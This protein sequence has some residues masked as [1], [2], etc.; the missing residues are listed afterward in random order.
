MNDLKT[1]SSYGKLCICDID[2]LKGFLSMFRRLFCLL[3]VI[4]FLVTAVPALAEETESIFSYDFNLA[5][6]LNADSFPLMQ[7]SR[8][9][10]YAALLDRLSFKGTYSWSSQTE[11]MDLDLVMYYTDQPSLSYP[12]HIYGSKAWLFAT[13]PLINNEIMFFDL[14]GL[15]EYAVKVRN[16]LGL[17]LPYL[18]LLYPYATENSLAGLVSAWQSVFAP[19]KKSGKAS[20]AQFRKLSAL[21]AE[22]LQNNNQL[23]WWINGLAYGSK[24]PSVV[25]NE[26]FN[27]PNYI[28]TVTSGRPVSVSVTPGSEIWMDSAGSVLFSRMDKDDNLS[29]LLSLPASGNGY[30]PYFSFVRHD[31]D[32]VFS[33]ETAASVL[34]NPFV[35]SAESD[36]TAD[37]YA[38]YEEDEEY[39]HL[40]E[41]LLDFRAGGS[42]LPLAQSVDAAFTL[43]A[44]VEG[45]LYPNYAFVIRGETKK[46]GDVSLALC[47]PGDNPSGAGEIL[48][49]AGTITPSAEPSF[50]PRY[51]DAEYLSGTHQ[52]F[53]FNEQSLAN[54][55]DKVLSSLIR[56][57]FSFV[58]E[59][60]TA[61]C[62]SFLDDLTESGLLDMFLN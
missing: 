11:T 39:E 30:A 34:R 29:L 27:L 54:F 10:S 3:C 16:T 57:V 17:D 8:A 6:S 31:Q 14:S 7:R 60:P 45:A 59:A 61:A 56:G 35:S 13:S 58:A 9:A 47:K 19:F 41:V 18:A 38:E 23:N 53:S 1:A 51:F 28:N 2:V 15:M 33:F 24:C 12:L 5:F 37:E 36:E 49:C 26:L 42:G 50:T 48:R 40:P 43:S 52:V 46:E 44:S 20:S 21:W 55:K 32:Q 62:Q 25:E 22:Q 4:A